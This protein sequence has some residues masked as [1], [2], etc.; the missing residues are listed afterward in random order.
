MVEA[1]IDNDILLKLC[2]YGLHE[3]LVSDEVFDIKRLYYL[4]AAKYVLR[5]V[6]SRKKSTIPEEHIIQNLNAVLEQLI[7]VEPTPAELIL[8]AR[9]ETLANER[10]LQL[11]A[12]ESQLCAIVVSRQFSYLLTGDKRAIISIEALYHSGYLPT[13]NDH[14]LCLEQLFLFWLKAS[15]NLSAL[16]DQ[17]CANQ[18]CDK[19]LTLSFACHSSSPSLENCA[20]GLNSYINHL[21]T[22]ASNVLNKY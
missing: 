2:I 12:G 5:K 8:A 9:L 18:S 22:S 20:Y 15:D 17:I 6:V 10:N 16:R 7:V 4:G 11:D 3:K 21:R 19:S 1:A 14:L 13:I